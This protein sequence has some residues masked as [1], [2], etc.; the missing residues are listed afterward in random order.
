[1]HVAYIHQHFVTPGESSGT[2]SYE[3]AQRL[4]A[5]GHRVTMLTGTHQ[6]S[7]DERAAMGPID[8]RDVDGIDVRYINVPYSNSMSGARRWVAFSQFAKLAAREAIGVR[9]DLVFASSTPLHAGVA[10]RKA[11]RR[12]RVPFVFEV[13]D[14]WPQ[15]LIEMGV[16]TNPLLKWHMRRMEQAI[17]KAAAHVVVLAPGMTAHLVASGVAEDETTFIPN[18]CDLELFRPDDPADE[19]CPLAAGEDFKLVFT[20]AHGIA[21][22]L[23]AVLDAAAVLKQRGVTGVRFIFIGGGGLRDRLM[24]RAADEGLGDLTIFHG[25][26]PKAELAQIVP[27]MDVGMQILANVEHFQQCTSPNKFFDYIAGGLPVLNN[28]PG[29]LAGLIET[30]E[31]GFVVPPEDPEAFADAV[32][33]LRADRDRLA[34]MGRNARALAEREFNRDEMGHRFVHT[35]DAVYGREHS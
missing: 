25:P 6:L 14:I 27:Q 29:W 30:N 17:Y 1:M 4:L 7:E 20:G 5:A 28:Y 26:V 10:G 2:R 24:R 23:D 15:A 31:C 9:P 33:S 34:A 16:L 22:G 8:T 3:F 32:V 11:A 21:N 18:S 13:R 35:L 12:C 19:R